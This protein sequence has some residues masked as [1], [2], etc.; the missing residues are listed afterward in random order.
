M[1]SS[2]LPAASMIPN[3]DNVPSRNT[4]RRQR[5]QAGHGHEQQQ[6]QPRG[7]AFLCFAFC[8]KYIPTG[9]VQ[10]LPRPASNLSHTSILANLSH[11]P[12]LDSSSRLVIIIVIITSKPTTA[13]LIATGNEAVQHKTASIF[14]ISRSTASDAHNLPSVLLLR[15]VNDLGTYWASVRSNV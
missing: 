5:L 7:T 11:T 9:A 14:G 13:R 2:S 15:E 1:I 4:S 8:R 3:S 6:S 12:M 10:K